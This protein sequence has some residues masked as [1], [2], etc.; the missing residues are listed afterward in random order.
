MEVVEVDHALGRDTVGFGRQ[1]ELRYEPPFRATGVMAVSP[2]LKQGGD[3][4]SKLPEGTVTFMFT[5]I[6]GSTPVAGDGP[7]DG[8]AS[9]ER[10]R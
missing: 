9:T 5:D 2:S 7:P 8:V 10:D 6:E 1:L 4:S 3:M